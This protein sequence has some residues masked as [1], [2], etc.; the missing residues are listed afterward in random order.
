MHPQLT[1]QSVG[2]SSLVPSEWQ[3][4]VEA[5]PLPDATA[6]GL[7]SFADAVLGRLDTAND[8]TRATIHIVSACEARDAAAIH[9]ATRRRLFGIF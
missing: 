6:G 5:P 3:Q 7:A 2:C 8:R 9:Q 4:G 1:T